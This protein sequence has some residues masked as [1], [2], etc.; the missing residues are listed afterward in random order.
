MA[1]KAKGLSLTIKEKETCCS[2]E[3]KMV[4]SRSSLQRHQ[5][6]GKRLGLEFMAK[7]KVQIK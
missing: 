6:L 7:I 2:S 1:E 5:R 3:A 4:G